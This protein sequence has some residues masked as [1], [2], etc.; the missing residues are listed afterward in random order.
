MA[1]QGISTKANAFSYFFVFF[2]KLKKENGFAFVFCVRF[3]FGGIAVGSISSSIVKSLTLGLGSA[4][5]GSESESW[6]K[7]SSL[8]PS[9]GGGTT[10][11][12]L[13]GGSLLMSLQLEL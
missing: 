9:K 11:D 7:P 3:G 2:K 5:S 10:L 1:F 4:N 6:K 12:R 13:R 8:N